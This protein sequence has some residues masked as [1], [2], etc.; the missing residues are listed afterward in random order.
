[1][2]Q[3]EMVK[4]VKITDAWFG[5]HGKPLLKMK[6]LG[7]YAIAFLAGQLFQSWSVALALR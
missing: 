7:L 4:K 3:M 6:G 2:L 5:K 1:M